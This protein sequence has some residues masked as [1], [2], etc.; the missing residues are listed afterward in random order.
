MKI[1]LRA[2]LDAIELRPAGDGLELSRRRSITLSP[3]QGARTAV[4][5]RRR[6]VVG[7]PD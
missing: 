6:A 1:V 2:V 3:R 4:G 5:E 7:A